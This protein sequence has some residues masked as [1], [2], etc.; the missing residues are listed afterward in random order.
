MAF[1]SEILLCE[2][3]KWWK[4]V[5]SKT[6]YTIEKTKTSSEIVLTVFIYKIKFAVGFS[7]KIKLTRN[8]QI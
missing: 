6:R 2:M 1:P 8:S 5:Y 4:G 7:Q 3:A